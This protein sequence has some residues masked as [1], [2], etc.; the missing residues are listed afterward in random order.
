MLVSSELRLLLGGIGQSNLSYRYLCLREDRLSWCGVCSFHPR[1]SLVL[2]S[3][4]LDVLFDLVSLLFHW[5][6]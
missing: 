1:L 2:L 3:V 5:V 4:L 6:K